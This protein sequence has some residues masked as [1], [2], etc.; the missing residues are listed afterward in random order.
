[1]TELVKR[2]GWN[3]EEVRVERGRLDEVFRAI[4]CG[5]DGRGALHA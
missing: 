2:E 3:V 4:T 5:G 1:M